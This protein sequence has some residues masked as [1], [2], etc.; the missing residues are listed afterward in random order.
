MPKVSHSPSPASSPDKKSASLP[1]PPPPPVQ[2]S[3]GD[4]KVKSEFAEGEEEQPVQGPLVISHHQPSAAKVEPTED[5]DLPDPFDDFPPHLWPFT[6]IVTRLSDELLNPTWTVRH[7]AALGLQALL[8]HQ[9]AHGGKE[10]GQAEEENDALHESWTAE[11]ACKLLEL[12]ARDRF[13]DY[14]GDTVLAPVREC[15]S[16]ALATLLELM[17]DDGRER[18]RAI[19]VQMV[20]QEDMGVGGPGKKGHIWQVRH[21]GLLGLQFL[22]ES[23]VAR[24]LPFGDAAL[25]ELGDVCLVGYVFSF[26]GLGYMAL[27]SRVFCDCRLSSSD[28]DVRAA[29]AA[30]IRPIV[31]TLIR[32]NPS[33]TEAL[34]STVWHCLED[35]ADDLSSSVSNIMALCTDLLADPGVIRDLLQQP[36]GRHLKDLP[37]LLLPYFRHTI[38]EVRSA[39]LTTLNYLFKMTFSS[40][41][42]SQTV[43]LENRD[44]LRLL[45]QNLLIE[46]THDVVDLSQQTFHSLIHHMQ[47]RSP[48][49]VQ[50]LKNLVISW[51]GLASVGPGSTLDPSSFFTPT[52][53]SRN[54]L[55]VPAMRMDLSL[56]NEDQII[57]GRLESARALGLVASMWPAGAEVQAFHDLIK[58][59]QSSESWF[60]R[61]YGGYLT[62]EWTKALQAREHTM[63]SSSKDSLSALFSSLMS[64]T[65]PPQYTELGRHFT[66]LE[67]ECEQLLQ[68]AKGYKIPAKRLPSLRK[69]LTLDGA[70][71]LASGVVDAAPQRLD[72]SKL[73]ALKDRK[74]RVLNV[75]SNCR[76]SK[77]IFDV[78]VEAS[79]GGAVVALDCV[80]QKL[81]PL[82]RGLMNSLKV[83]LIQH[84]L[85][86]LALKLTVF[87]CSSRQ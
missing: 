69:P 78:R 50:A 67:R 5:E 15:A 47:S 34:V 30:M 71:E 74:E 56:V 42:D 22:V 36:P 65:A 6:S 20:K 77:D 11:L 7:G 8:R 40:E 49:S 45:F 37:A 23:T 13:G 64:A 60:T 2:S 84:S 73:S 54:H 52:N 48:A 35:R 81:N 43:S 25:A 1:P 53:V 46:G 33:V 9:G 4:V 38:T 21:S 82:I 31:K 86:G 16:N 62:S 17:S 75:I 87:H 79:R 76:S 61:S 10:A 26:L 19:L 85:A 27:C 70:K 12:L 39:V 28:D 59:S 44:V 58:E 51:Y 57:G 3:Q 14:V 80:P 18:V 66:I 24:E 29:A 68:E 41:G 32:S 55:D 83:S 72:E 63:D